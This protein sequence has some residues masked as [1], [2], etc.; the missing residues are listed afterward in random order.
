M[1]IDRQSTN[2]INKPKFRGARPESCLVAENLTKS[3]SKKELFTNISFGISR[4]EKIALIAEN[5]TGKT[6]LLNIL[7]DL[8]WPD[9]GKYTYK[10]DL[11]V[12]YL[13]QEPDLNNELTVYQAFFDTDD[14]AFNAVKNYEKAL[15]NHD[16][17]AGLQA[18]MDVMD[19]VNGWDHEVKIKQ[20]LADFKLID[21]VDTKIGTL[22]G[23]QRKRVAIALAFLNEPDFI[24]IDEPTNHLDTDVIENL[25]KRLSNPLLTIFMV[26]HDRYFLERV[27][28][29]I[30]EL[31][32]G[33]LYSYDGSYSNFLEARQ[34]RTDMHLKKRDRARNLLRRELVWMNCQPRARGT[35]AQHRIDKFQD[36][37][38]EAGKRLESKRLNISFSASRLGK[39][40]I[41]IEN[42]S[43][44]FGE[45]QIFSD[46]S[47]KFQ[48]R[49]RLG[50]TGP[51]GSGKST[52]L[53]ILTNK[54]Q[55]DTG[56]I[57]I[58]E[59]IKL[60]YYMQEGMKFDENMNILDTVMSVSNAIQLSTGAVLDAA[61]M[62]ERFLF[63]RQIQD[64]P[65]HK[66]S[67]GEK[68]RL[69]LLMVL[70]DNPNFL[71]MD[72]PTNDLDI[73]TLNILEEFLEEF[74]GCLAVVSHD[75]YF[76]DKVCTH[77]LVFTN[78]SSEIKESYGGW[79][80]WSMNEESGTLNKNDD[81]PKNSPAKSKK[82]SV[83]SAKTSSKKVS[84]KKASSKKASSKKENSIS[85]SKSSSKKGLT[86][87]EKR[88][89]E[90][91]EA[92]IKE[93]ELLK[94]GLE[95]KIEEFSAGGSN[96]D[97]Q[98]LTATSEELEK[99]IENIDTVSE[100]W[101]ELLEKEEDS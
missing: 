9:Q 66:L 53:N 7:A 97:Y 89:I 99:T 21:L 49:D 52:F 69:Y 61:T 22:S 39:K 36:L 77:L 50:I 54:I 17:Q 78:D 95:K 20:A 96:L 67:G 94:T 19:R 56:S 75:R 73:L 14:P 40:T 16:D 48:K 79:T 38:K 87:R 32:K 71:I 4:G 51:N 47:F 101:L 8:D 6:T 42:I 28:T 45:N 62:L 84:S 57:E 81:S 34:E 41:E 100:R 92:K 65:V 43:K 3:Y 30:F 82:N 13:K 12:S 59:T 85:S 93:L 83:S 15:E 37:N 46:F 27:C 91:I 18:A 70:M 88:E 35:K 23:G 25:E 31:N 11:K 26:T 5:G 68:R 55:P 10:K 63:E 24:L 1:S 60:G 72:E 64:Q 90:E 29:R 2:I 80:A 86:W 98:E 74:E 76:L 44:S 33:I 58:G